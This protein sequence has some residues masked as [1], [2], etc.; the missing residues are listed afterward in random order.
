MILEYEIPK[1]DGDVGRP[2]VFVALEGRHVERKVDILLEC[3]ETQRAKRWFRA[4]TFEAMMR[5]R[6]IE[7]AAKCGLAEA[8]CGRKALLG[9]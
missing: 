9:T 5:L 8:F 7:A 2:N 1:Y 6:G 3:Y 4:E